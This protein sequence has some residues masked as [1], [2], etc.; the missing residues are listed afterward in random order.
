MVPPFLARLLLPLAIAGAAAP[1]AAAGAPPHIPLWPGTPPG[2]EGLALEQRVVERS[3]DPRLPDRYVDNIGQPFLSVYRP[4]RPDGRGLLVVPGGGYQRVVVDKEGTAL[5]PHFAGE[6]GLT[7]FVLHYRLPGE[8]HREPRDV[9][10]ADA[11]R[12]IRLVRQRA[13]EWGIDPD[14]VG[15]MGFSAGGHVAASL[16]TR[17]AER[18][19]P[20]VDEADR[21]PARPAYAVLVYP[22]IDMGAHAHP[23]SRERLLG[24]SPDAAAVR[25]YSLQNRVDATT[26]P[27]FLL[28]AQDDGTVPV[29][30]TL[31]LDAAL[32]TAGIDH[33]T[34]LYAH[35]GHG[36]GVRQ[37]HGSLALWPAM[38]RA[39]IDVQAPPRD[40]GAGR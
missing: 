10:L 31:L 17:H 13:A 33:E 27:V 19:Y 22:V 14:S 39:W 37:A 6:D 36:F 32:R 12:A 23:G 11:Q 8:G 4:A 9:P 2:S 5:V 25:A 30:N 29:E 21:Q 1:A 34:H 40:A 3:S 26:P 16:A 38:V 18:V 28:H 7:L 24:L 20:A 15:V 35:G